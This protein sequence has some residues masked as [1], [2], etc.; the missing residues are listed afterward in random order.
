[1][2]ARLP[3]VS[4]STDDP[5]LLDLFT[6][7]A[8][9]QGRVSNLYRTLANAPAMLGAWTGMAW[10][11][12]H[13]P[14]LERRLRELAIMRVAQRSH[15]VYEWAHHWHLALDSGV[16][17]AQL[18]A[19][20]DWRESSLFDER[21][22]AVLNYTDAVVELDVPD[23]IFEPIR[24]WFDRGHLIELT[25]TVSFY[26]NV[27]RTLVALRVELEPEIDAHLDAM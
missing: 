2:T 20:R 7:A 12:R 24:R 13:A 11:L 26:C 6:Q 16:P 5:V 8:A 1:V 15:A 10:P 18:R 27:A 19:L 14:K 3:M 4:E 25:L 9:Q 22:R 21:D 23:H 17:E